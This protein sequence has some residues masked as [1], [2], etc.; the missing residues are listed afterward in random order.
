MKPMRRSIKQ[1][2]MPDKLSWVIS[3]MRL[4]ITSLARQQPLYQ[5]NVPPFHPPAPPPC[6]VSLRGR[7]LHLVVQLADIVLTPER[8]EYE[9]GVWGVEGMR[10]ECIVASGIAYFGESNISQSPLAFRCEI[11]EPVS[12]RHNDSRGVEAVYGLR[13][14]EALVQPLGAVD[15]CSGRCIAFP[16]IYQHRVAPFSLLDRTQPGHRS[17]LVVFLVDPAI[18]IVSTSRVPPQQREWMAATPYSSAVTDVL[19]GVRVLSEVVD[20]YLD[21]PMS[22]EEAEQHREH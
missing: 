19:G 17:I 8:P 3:S 15:T 12:L 9:G 5:P 6:L 16:N 7:R 21:W 14:E 10:N 20:S 11:A 13:T 22:R 1:K 4:S 2:R 18:S